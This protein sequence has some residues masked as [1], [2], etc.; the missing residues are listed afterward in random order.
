VNLFSTFWCCARCT[1]CTKQ[2]TVSFSL[3]H[4]AHREAAVPRCTHTTPDDIHRRGEPLHSSAGFIAN[5]D[6]ASVSS[7]RTQRPHKP[8]PSGPEPL[9]SDGLGTPPMAQPEPAP[10]ERTTREWIRIYRIGRWNEPRGTRRRN[11]NPQR[12]TAQH[13]FSA[14]WDPTRPTSN[15][16]ASHARLP[17]TVNTDNNIYH[18]V[19][20]A[21]D[22]YGDE[23][24]TYRRDTETQ[25]T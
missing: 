10:D 17:A 9:D 7:A 11:K 15:G 2:T 14:L 25:N 24:Y 18:H 3:A 4:N 22:P 12:A 16:S 19:E 1:R 5:V 21:R 6:G 13:T 8:A 23:V 20:T